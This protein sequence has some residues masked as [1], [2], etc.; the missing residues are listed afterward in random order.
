MKMNEEMKEP[1]TI[2]I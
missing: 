2:L 1:T